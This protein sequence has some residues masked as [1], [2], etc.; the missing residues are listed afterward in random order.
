MDVEIGYVLGHS[1]TLLFNR[2]L[3]SGF[4]LQLFFMYSCHVSP[5]YMQLNTSF[6]SRAGYGYF[7]APNKGIRI[8]VD[9]YGFAIQ[10]PSMRVYL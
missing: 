6:N 9:K 7:T 2:K 4:H 3:Y 1:S 5:R 10:L 8:R